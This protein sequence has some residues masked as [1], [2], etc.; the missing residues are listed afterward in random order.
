MSSINKNHSSY[1]RANLIVSGIFE[2]GMIDDWTNEKLSIVSHNTYTKRPATVEEIAKAI[3][4][5]CSNG[6]LA[7]STINLTNGQIKLIYYAIGAKKTR[8]YFEGFDLAGKSSVISEL[9]KVIP[10]YN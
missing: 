4:F 9:S 2:S 8:I 3:I 1:I 5:C 7:G 6:Y 10:S